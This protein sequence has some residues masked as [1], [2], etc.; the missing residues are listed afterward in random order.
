MRT[1]RA[2]SSSSSSGGVGSG[3][4]GSSSGGGGG[5]SGGGGGESGV[6]RVQVVCRC[7]PLNGKEHNDGERNVIRLNADRRSVDVLGNGSGS[8]SSKKTFTFD[9]VFTDSAT[10][11]EV[12]DAVVQPMVEEVLNVSWES[13][14]RA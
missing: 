8:K 6:S 7:R 1:K 9:K 11:R 10:Q 13:E 4:N 5:G 2:S 12:Y 14:S 3:K